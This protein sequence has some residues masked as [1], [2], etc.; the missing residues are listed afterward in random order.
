MSQKSNAF[1][2]LADLDDDPVVV[3]IK[4]VDAGSSSGV[5]PEG[6][7][8][9]SSPPAFTPPQKPRCIVCGWT[10]VPAQDWHTSCKKCNWKSKQIKE[11]ERM[12]KTKVIFSEAA[13]KASKASKNIEEDSSEC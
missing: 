10:F 4:F 9:K 11:Q 7:F 13:I 2:A 1:A 12:K 6:D 5:K 8:K 3:E